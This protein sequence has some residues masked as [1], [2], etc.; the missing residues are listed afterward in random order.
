[1][2]FQFE[3]KFYIIR[4]RNACSYQLQAFR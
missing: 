3:K 4:I 1:M 2:T